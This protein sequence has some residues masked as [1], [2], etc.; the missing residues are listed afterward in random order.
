M[1]IAAESSSTVSLTPETGMTTFDPY[2]FMVD[3]AYAE[4]TD[5]KLFVTPLHAVVRCD[6]RCF[7]PWRA[8][9]F[10]AQGIGSD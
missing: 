5:L 3:K 4:G 9:R 6:D 10:L 1:L 8:L 2:R 7:G